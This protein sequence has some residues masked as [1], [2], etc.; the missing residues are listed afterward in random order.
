MFGTKRR[1]GDLFGM[2]LA[3]RSHQQMDEVF[4]EANKS[5]GHRAPIEQEA[6]LVYGYA[7]GWLHARNELLRERHEHMMEFHPDY[8]SSWQERLN[9]ARKGGTP[10]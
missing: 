3:A 5:I 9:E 1:P 2:A 8:A 10:R 6:F 4:K 7:D